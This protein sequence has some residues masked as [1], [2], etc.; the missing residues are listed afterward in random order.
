MYH[1]QDVVAGERFKLLRWRWMEHP[2]RGRHGLLRVTEAI[3][4]R[5]AANEADE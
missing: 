3:V 4:D 1:G 2:I 5:R